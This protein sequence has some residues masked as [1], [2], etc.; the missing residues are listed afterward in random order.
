MLERPRD[1]FDKSRDPRYSHWRRSDWEQV[2][3]DVMFKA[4]QAKF[5]QHEYL[6]RMLVETKERKLVEH[7]PY[8]SYW[9]DGGDGSGKNR[10]G[11]LLMILRGDLTPKPHPRA[12]SP[13]PQMHRHPPSPPVLVNDQLQRDAPTHTSPPPPLQQQSEWRTPHFSPDPDKDDGLAPQPTQCQTDLQ[14]NTASQNVPVSNPL[15]AART[16]VTLAYSSV[17]AGASHVGPSATI[18]TPLNVTQPVVVQSFQQYPP[19]TIPYQPNPQ[20]TIMN[21]QSTMLNQQVTMLNQQSIVPQSTVPNPQLIPQS[22]IP[23]P[24]LAPQST[25]PNPQLT[26]PNPQLNPQSTMLT[27]QPTMLTPQ[28]TIPNPQTTVQVPLAGQPPGVP[29][30]PNFQHTPPLSNTL[31]S[32][33]GAAQQ[34]TSTTVSGGNLMGEFTNS[35]TRNSLPGYRAASA[36]AANVHPAMLPNVQAQTVHLTTNP[37]PTPQDD[38]TPMDTT[39]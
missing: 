2:K 11:E 35:L 34:L 36:N 24:Q 28:S 32:A 21:Q 30:Q 20:S 14:Q 9:G 23:N 12:P 6:R 16:Q 31:P 8:D 27:P 22:T 10:L 38:S 19:Q 37:V 1:A 18:A 5:T 29:I 25:I 7:S 13:P 15:P 17:V 33:A 3:E 4:L 39:N 26:V